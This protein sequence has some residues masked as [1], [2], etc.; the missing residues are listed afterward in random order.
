VNFVAKSRL[1][2]GAASPF[3]IRRRSAQALVLTTVNSSL[4]NHDGKGASG[5]M[6]IARPGA[7]NG[8]RP[9]LSMHRHTAD[10][11]LKDG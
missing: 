5:P 8:G 1:Q 11:L 7:I 3:F 6:R 9:R 2:F 10:T 4:R